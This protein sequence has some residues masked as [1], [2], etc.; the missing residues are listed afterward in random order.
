MAKWRVVAGGGL[1]W[2]NNAD[3]SIGTVDATRAE[4][5]PSGALCF[6]DATDR[7]IEAFAPSMWKNVTRKEDDES[8]TKNV[9][10]TEKKG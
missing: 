1:V 5:S 3:K 4:V 2:T 9:E 10:N 7:L 8:D 6:F